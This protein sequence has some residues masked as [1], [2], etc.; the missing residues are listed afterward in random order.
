MTLVIRL[1]ILPNYKKRTKSKLAIIDIDNVRYCTTVNRR[2]KFRYVHNFI[3]DVYINFIN[4]T[5]LLA[6]FYFFYYFLLFIFSINIVII[7][8]KVWIN[9]ESILSL[10]LHNIEYSE[11]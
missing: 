1:L 6:Y 11:N 2:I 9:K 8:M 7:L 3:I 10:F 5:F 4:Y